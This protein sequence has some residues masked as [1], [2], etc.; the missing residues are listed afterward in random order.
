MYNTGVM[1]YAVVKIGSQ[2]FLVSEGEEVNVFHLQ[3]KAEDKQI[4]KEVMLVIDDGNVSVGTPFVEKALVTGAIV[5][6][7]KGEKI[8][9][10]TYKAK[11]RTRRVKGHRDMLTRIK[12]EKISR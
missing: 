1:K 9:V 4:F 12:I 2:Q 8:R 11:S 5:G 6:Q 7:V 3:G 10:A